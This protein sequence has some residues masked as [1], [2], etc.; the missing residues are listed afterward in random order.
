MERKGDLDWAQVL[1]SFFVCLKYL[2]L[3]EK[4]NIIMKKVDLIQKHCN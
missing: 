4:K 2:L 1:F 3:N